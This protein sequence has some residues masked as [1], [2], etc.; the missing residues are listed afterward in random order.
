MAIATGAVSHEHWFKLG[1]SLTPTG[2][3]RALLSWSASMFEYLMPLL[4]MRDYPGTLLDET[5]DAVVK[6]Q[7][8]Y[9]AQRGVPWG[10][11]ESAYFAPRPR[12]ELPV[13]RVRRSRAGPEAWPG[14]GPRHCPLCVDAGRA[15]CAARRARQPG[16]PGRRRAMVGRV[17]L[18]RIHRLHARAAA[19]RITRAASCCAPG[20]RTIKA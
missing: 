16:A 9:G 15:A 7:I 14:R 13:P 17:R 5:Y 6:R 3:S 10:I 8:E 20:W 18:L 2:S 12:Q 19:A 11:S 1:R 4:V